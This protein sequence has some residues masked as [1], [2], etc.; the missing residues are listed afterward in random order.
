MLEGSRQYF[1][2][3]L[4]LGDNSKNI[5]KGSFWNKE[6]IMSILLRNKTIMH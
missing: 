5:Y 4:V 3:I 2:I 6:K 1:I